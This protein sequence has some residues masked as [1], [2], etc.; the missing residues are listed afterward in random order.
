MV[1]KHFGSEEGY[2]D[3]DY[4]YYYPYN[5]S[6]YFHPYYDEGYT[7][8][9][10][11][12][13]FWMNDCLPDVATERPVVQAIA[14]ACTSNILAKQYAPQ[15]TMSG[16]VGNNMLV[17]YYSISPLIFHGQKYHLDGPY[18]PRRRVAAASAAAAAEL[19][20]GRIQPPARVGQSPVRP[21]T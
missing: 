6:T 10:S 15:S 19:V 18:E 14:E 20:K 13:Q 1:I 8:T 5:A 4:N 3:V 12:E 2:L 21:A 7:N 17:I 9:T 11:N 16:G